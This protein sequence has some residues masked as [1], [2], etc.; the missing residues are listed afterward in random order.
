MTAVP[1]RSSCLQ[2]AATWM[3]SSFTLSQP[4]RMSVSSWG[5]HASLGC[6]RFKQA[7][8][9]VRMKELWLGSDLPKQQQPRC[10]EHVSPTDIQVGQSGQPQRRQKRLFDVASSQAGHLLAVVMIPSHKPTTFI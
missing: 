6:L 3:M 9:A 8:S 4:R 7:L 2:F 10:C 5:L 1:P